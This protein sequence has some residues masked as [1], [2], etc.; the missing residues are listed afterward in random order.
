MST[1]NNSQPDALERRPEARAIRVE[2]L[3]AEVK[4]GRIRIP[5]FQRAL[6][7]ES[8]DARKLLD[9]IY[10]GYPIGTLLLWET[11]AE[12]QE[13]HFGSISIAAH[14]RP[15]AWWVVD[16]QQRVV[17]LIRVLLTIHPSTDEF[18]LYFDLDS[19]EFALASAIKT[20]KDDPARWLPLA[21]VLDS[22]Q[23]FQWML[24]QRPEGHRR[25][26][27][28]RVG[29]RIRE[30][31]I[32]IYVVHTDSE[33]TL[34]EIFGRVNN[35]GKQLQAFEVFDALHGARAVSRPA[36]VADIVEELRELSFGTVEQKILYRLLRVLTGADVTDRGG[37]GVLR[38][39]DEEAR[40]AYADTAAAAKQVIQ[41]LK[42]DVGIV[43]YDLLPYKQPLVTLG[44]FFHHHPT[45]L[46]RSRELLARWL[47]RG[48]LNGAHRGDTVSTRRALDQ[49]DQFDEE[50]SV[51]NMLAQVANIPNEAP[52]AK[53]PF[54]FRF[55]YG[56]LQILALI[57]LSPRDLENGTPLAIPKLFE[58]TEREE[59]APV[60]EITFS[61]SEGL[62]RS[63]ANRLLHPRKIGMR[64][65]LSNCSDEST[66]K[67]HAVTPEAHEALRKG[68]VQAFLQ[69]RA[70]TLDKHFNNFFAQRARW[71]DTDRPSVSSLAITEED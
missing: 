67:S 66:L 17:S 25:E 33:A 69:L 24:D 62:E 45:P 68:D 35:S 65:L 22:E 2:D 51:Q 47:W 71:E 42:L 36:T 3:L 61:A 28:V 11:Q 19:A 40:K 41:F 48:A 60:P 30:Y 55:A 64:Q 37:K 12:A 59:E 16:G 26:Q 21:V 63:T 9:S 23:L 18:A 43:H 8:E 7:W 39:S 6:R 46:P 52:S 38:L 29:K 56:K 1:N 44:K 32:P 54:N 15:D 57:E 53:E 27:A 4:R 14:L 58:R 13:L 5:P 10:R 31:D 20:L 50:R 49:I 34:R 70:S